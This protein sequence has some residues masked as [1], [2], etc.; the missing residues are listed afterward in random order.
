ALTYL[1]RALSQRTNYPEVH[2]DLGVVYSRMGMP[3]NA[4]EEFQTSLSQKPDF[5]PVFLA[6]SEAY[7]SS[8]KH[9][10]ARRV[11]EDYIQKFSGRGSEYVTEAQRRLR[12]ISG[13]TKGQ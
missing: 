13:E 2:H 10:D 1:R 7:E 5:E 9:A 3:E 12:L 4:I 8:G 11:L 6:L